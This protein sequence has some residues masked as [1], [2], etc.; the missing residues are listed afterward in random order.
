VGGL[1]HYF[2][3]EG[4]ATT[5]I[6]L[7]REHTEAMKPPRALWVPF[8]LG[9]PFGVPNAPDFQQQVLLAVLELIEADEGPVLKDY[10]EEAPPIASE[11]TWACPVD[12][13]RR[14]ETLSDMEK[15]YRAF[16]QEIGD[17][18]PWYDLAVKNRERTTVGVSGIGIDD[19][20][21]F[22]IA[23]AKGKIP[24]NPR[25]DLSIPFVLNSAVD[26]LKAYYSEAVT[27]QPGEAFPSSTVLENW[28][29]HETVAAKVLF[30]VRKSCENSSD[31][32][33]K[34]VCSFLLIPSGQTNGQSGF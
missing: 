13:G 2:E 21:D 8:E 27:A 10:T 3:E 19:L 23:F 9:R 11:T 32:I 24:E 30:A 25:Q 15:L 16:K 12:F 7:I 31:N 1:A 33:L 14:E 20:A 26:D 28:F 34:T 5:Q 29:W 18:R 22:I 6:S 17:L 4:L